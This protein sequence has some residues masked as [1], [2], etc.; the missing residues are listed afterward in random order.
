MFAICNGGKLLTKINGN[1]KQ[2]QQK[3]CTELHTEV[4]NFELILNTGIVRVSAQ[5]LKGGNFSTSEETP[6]TSGSGMTF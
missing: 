2:Q 6:E 5:K 4:K 1:S 3:T